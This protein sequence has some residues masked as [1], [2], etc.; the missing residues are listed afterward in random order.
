MTVDNT[1]SSQHDRPQ[2]GVR[3]PGI[4]RA[5]RVVVWLLAAAV[6]AQAVLAGLF[7]DGGDAWRAWHAVNGVLV[8]P[9]L[10]LIQVVLAVLVWRRGRGP[11][12][13][14]VAS[15]GLLVALLVQNVMGM[16]SQVAV[17][18][19]LGVAIVGLIGTLLARARTM[20]RP[21]TQP[22]S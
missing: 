8:L 4:G 2:T 18:V 17:H 3:Q 10:A 16:T 22:T 7:L 11:G 13:L 21:V 20:S 19:P 15:V 14:T 9:L 5:I 12:W 6:F 1:R